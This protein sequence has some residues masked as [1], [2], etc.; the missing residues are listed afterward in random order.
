MEKLPISYSS[1]DLTDPEALTVPE[2]KGIALPFLLGLGFVL[3]TYCSCERHGLTHVERMSCTI[4]LECEDV[5]HFVR[6]QPH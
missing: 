3:S 5:D 6:T 4:V 1:S 2:L